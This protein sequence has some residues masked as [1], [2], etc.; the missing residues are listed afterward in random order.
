[1]IKSSFVFFE[2]QIGRLFVNAFESMQPNLCE[3]PECFDAVD[4]RLTTDELT[5]AMMY[6]AMFFITNINKT[7]I[8]SPAIA[9]DHTSRINSSPDY[10]LQS[11]FLGI[12]SYLG[13]DLSIAL[14]QSRRWSFLWHRGLV[15]RE[16]V[17]GRSAIH[18]LP[19]LLRPVKHVHNPPQC[20]HARDV[21]IGSRC[22]D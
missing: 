1:M 8:S 16:H 7:V 4:V 19:L 15:C 12:G 18:P 11:G 14:E 13:V 17:W 6:P 5:L 21:Y 22:C 9:M 10:G 2:M 3:A 20:A